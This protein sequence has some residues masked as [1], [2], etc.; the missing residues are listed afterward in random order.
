MNVSIVANIVSI[1]KMLINATHVMM[2]ISSSMDNVHALMD[3]SSIQQMINAHI[4]IKHAQFVKDQ[5]HAM[6]TKVKIVMLVSILM[7]T[8]LIS[9]KRNVKE[10]CSI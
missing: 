7:E 5:N 9:V 1:V 3:T 4:A 8:I 6:E 10:V 2:I